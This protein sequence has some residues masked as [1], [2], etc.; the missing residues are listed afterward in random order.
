MQTL[1][2]SSSIQGEGDHFGWVIPVPNAPT[3]MTLENGL[4]FTPL[5]Y[6]NR[7]IITGHN[8][9][10]DGFYKFW[11]CFTVLALFHAFYNQL[12][13][14]RGE[15][16]SEFLMIL[17]IFMYLSLFSYTSISSYASDVPNNTATSIEILNAK[18]EGATDFNVLNAKHLMLLISG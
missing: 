8:K 9:E 5:H 13:R 2:L 12:Y 16:V 11:L 7:E 3:E 6:L 14:Q 1:V 15:K 10:Q 4:F 17:I 18:S